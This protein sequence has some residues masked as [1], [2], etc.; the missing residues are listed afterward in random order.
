MQTM[1]SAPHAP[2]DQL[3]GRKFAFYPALAGIEHN[4]WRYEKA[5]WSEV[6]VTN[7]QTNAQIWIPRR[8][9]GEISSTDD[10]ILIVGLTRELESKGGMIVPVQK[11]VLTM[12]GAPRVTPETSSTAPGVGEPKPVSGLRFDRSD[13]GM[14][15]LIGIAVAAACVLGLLILNSARIHEI[16]Q[17]VTFT[18]ADQSFA[19]LGSHDDYL[20]VT[21]KLG[22]PV[23]DHPQESGTI[24]FRALG[25]PERKYTVILMGR[26]PNSMLYVGTVDQDWRPIHSA[27]ERT[28][29]LLRTLKPF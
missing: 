17:R 2:L 9:V 13:R 11:R 18:G 20:S 15:K 26:D 1:G 25:Y 23:T 27:N 29:A 7:A 12:T 28:A 22:T 6:L 14:L 16:R 5:T 4:E 10:P 19:N 21:Q 3:A 24:L 8:Y